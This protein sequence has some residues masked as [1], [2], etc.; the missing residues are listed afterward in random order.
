MERKP[1]NFD[2]FRLLLPGDDHPKLGKNEERTWHLSL[3]PG[4]LSGHEVCPRRT[5]GCSFSCVGQTGLS[6]V[7]ANIMEARI[8]KT[9]EF[10]ADRRGFLAQLDREL[11]H[12]SH[13]Q[14][15]LGQLAYV[16]LN[17]YSDIAW[18]SMLPLADYPG[19]RFYDYTKIRSRAI[20]SASRARAF[21][22]HKGRQIYR[23]CY[24]D[25][26]RDALPSTL[27]VIDA[28][29]TVAVVLSD[30]QYVPSAGIVGKMPKAYLGRKLIDGDR[31]DNRFRDPPGV[32][33][34]LRL[35]G[36]KAE[37]AHARET[38]FAVPSVQFMVTARAARSAAQ[39]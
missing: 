39:A 17:A 30:I 3:A 26:E 14:R 23:L 31:H 10:F 12:A 7:F 25:S 35:K 15:K 32:F 27:S 13:H 29:G 34:G 11:S 2:E 36:N 24:S 22:D 20:A 16:R 37:R 19:L 38:G 28:G 5:P 6:S 1:V 9:R 4:N 18:E 8:R 21:I 33:V